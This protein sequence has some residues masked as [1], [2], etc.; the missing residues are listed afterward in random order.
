MNKYEVSALVGAGASVLACGLCSQMIDPEIVT[1]VKEAAANIALPLIGLASGII[2]GRKI[3]GKHF[4]LLSNPGETLITTPALFVANAFFIHACEEAGFD[5]NG[6]PCI[7]LQL[8]LNSVFSLTRP[9]LKLVEKLLK[10]DVSQSD[11]NKAEADFEGGFPRFMMLV[12]THTLLPPGA[13]L[14]SDIAL[15]SH[16]PAKDF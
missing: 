3:Y 8:G 9:V 12:A 2:A 5:P 16:Q 11:V 1:N 7:A 4:N 15:N 10:P 6:A 14:C 13:A